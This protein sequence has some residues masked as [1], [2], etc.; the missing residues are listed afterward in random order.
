[1]S[2]ALSLWKADMMRRW[3]KQETNLSVVNV[4]YWLAVALLTI[5]L[6]QPESGKAEAVNFER[7]A[8]TVALTQE[9]PNL[10]I[11]R[12]TDLVSFFVLGHT[13]EGLVRYDQ[14]G[15]LVPG[16]AERWDIGER[17]M[18]FDLRKDAR[19]HNGDPVVAADFVYAWRLLI[20]PAN[21]APYAAVMYPIKNAERIQK[22]ELPV[23]QLG[24]RADGDHRL[25]I[26]PVQ[27]H[28]RRIGDKGAE[29]G[30]A[31]A[32]P[33]G[34]QA[35]SLWSSRSSRR[36]ILPVAVIGISA[37]NRTSDGAM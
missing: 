3:I 12:A 7:Q 22:G 5:A 24:I 23:E 29:N 13:T 33:V 25:V 6:M 11:T 28:R 20:D 15:R 18:T 31:G 36:L 4:A 37:T 27:P 2:L 26:E 1:M 19:W 30:G 32:V 34:H 21:A 17:Q 35:S 8:V 9:P 16:V 10:N 14:R